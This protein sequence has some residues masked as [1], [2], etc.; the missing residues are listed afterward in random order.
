MTLFVLVIKMRDFVEVLSI[1]LGG[2]FIVVFSAV[3]IWL[4]WNAV[5]PDIFGLPEISLMQGLGL[6][7]LSSCL[8][9]S[10]PSSS[11]K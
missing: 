2:V 7:I 11:S 8:F 1:V 3:P 10:T 6:S 4:L 9:K 5:V